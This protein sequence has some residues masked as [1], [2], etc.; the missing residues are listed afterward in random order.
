MAPEPLRGKECN[1]AMIRYTAAR[2]AEI[3]NISVE[4]VLQ[5]TE[6]NARKLFGV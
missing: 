4:E 5:I 1:S 3:N 2:L 6:Q